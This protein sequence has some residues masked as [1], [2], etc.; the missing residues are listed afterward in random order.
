MSSQKIQFS[1]LQSIL[2]NLGLFYILE[3]KLLLLYFI[4]FKQLDQMK[5]Q[6]I[7]F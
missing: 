1:D 2:G 4:F 6:V 5:D 3:N 7:R